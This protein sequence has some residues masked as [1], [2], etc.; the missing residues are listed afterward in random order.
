MSLMDSPTVVERPQK[1]TLKSK[2]KKRNQPNFI[3]S[4]YKNMDDIEGSSKMGSAEKKEASSSHEKTTKVYTPLQLFLTLKTSSA[5]LYSE[6]LPYILSD[7]QLQKYGFPLDSPHHPGRTTV[8]QKGTGRDPTERCCVRCGATFFILDDGTY[9]SG[10]PCH[11][12][13]K[14]LT[15]SNGVPAAG[16]YQC[17]N[18][19]YMS[20][21]CATWQFHVSVER[22]P[23]DVEYVK[24]REKRQL[25]RKKSHR[26]YALDCEM[27]YTTGGLEVAKIGIVGIDGLTVYESFVLP[28]NKILDYNTVYSG[29][30]ANDLKGVSTT[31]VD[32]QTFLLKLLNKDSILV[33]H[34]LENDLKALSLI[35]HKVV[36]T[37]VVFP[38]KYGNRYKRSLKSLALEYLNKS[39][40][41]S[42][43]GHDC[44]EDARTCMELMLW[45]IDAD[46]S[47]SETIS[48]ENKNSFLQ[49]LHYPQQQSWVDYESKC[50]WCLVGYEA[51][52]VCMTPYQAGFRESNVDYQADFPVSFFNPSY[53]IYPPNAKNSRTICA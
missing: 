36:D 50:A 23:K 1:A 37:S 28:K 3:K 27:C 33:G 39:I 41:D 17:C 35:H 30:T 4:K 20:E 48:D 25:N 22:S 16:A 11:F 47:N 51:N 45:K 42:T 49:N 26:V 43:C 29:I 14:K 34:G 8:Y 10:A 52:H 5:D 13:T 2:K 9:E 6:F 18:G 19:N 24:P 12:H 21:G 46:K 40:Q 31:L 38:H 32:V 15:S 53:F 44:I 7:E